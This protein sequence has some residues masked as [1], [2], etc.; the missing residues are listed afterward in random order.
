[1]VV[2]LIA[3]PATAADFKKK[4]ESCFLHRGFGCQFSPRGVALQSRVNDTF[5]RWLGLEACQSLEWLD[6]EGS[7]ITDDGLR[8]LN[9]CNKLERL[10]LEGLALSGAGFAKLKSLPAIKY[11]SL[12]SSG[13]SGEH[14]ENLAR[15]KTLSALKLEDTAI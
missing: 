12:E 13:V 2:L 15:F 7:S 9:G 3:S 1:L 4:F 5:L 8:S 11:I 6:V 10:D 14:L